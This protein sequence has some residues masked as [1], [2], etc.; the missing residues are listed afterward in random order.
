MKGEG[1]AMVMP[2]HGLVYQ[3]EI[4]MGAN[5]QHTV[6]PS[7]NLQTS[8]T[9]YATPAAKL[10]VLM[11]NLSALTTSS[12]LYTRSLQGCRMHMLV[13]GTAHQGQLRELVFHVG[14]DLMSHCMCPCEVCQVQLLATLAIQ[15]R[16]DL[17]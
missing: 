15:H 14:K 17:W 9:K 10:T 13:M 11:L 7:V 4:S 16:A 8:I 6:P 5:P 2:M 3:A 1:K 12:S